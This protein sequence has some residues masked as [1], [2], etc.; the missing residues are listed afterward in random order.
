MAEPPQRKTPC[1]PKVEVAS[2]RVKIHLSLP[3]LVIELQVRPCS[4]H[5]PSTSIVEIASSRVLKH[6]PLLN[7]VIEHQLNP[8]PSCASTDKYTFHLYSRRCKLQSTKASS[9]VKSSNRAPGETF[10]RNTPSTS[11]VEVTSS[12]YKSTFQH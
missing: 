5:M 3:N 1:N 10:Q 4:C 2:S 6:L 12:R 9:A 7:Q 11:I 8:C